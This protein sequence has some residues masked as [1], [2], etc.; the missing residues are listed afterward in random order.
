MF[1]S[2]SPAKREEIENIINRRTKPK[3]SG[4]DLIIGKGLQQLPEKAMTAVTQIF[5]AIIRTT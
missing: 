2:T 3:V 5:D 4:Y 1:I